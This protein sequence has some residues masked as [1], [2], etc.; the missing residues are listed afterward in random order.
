MG[1]EERN[2]M[3]EIFPIVHEAVVDTIEECAKLV[4]SHKFGN[5]D[6]SYSRHTNLLLIRLAKELRA[7]KHD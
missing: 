4:E 2:A 7:L 5:T 3:M 6:N 1:P